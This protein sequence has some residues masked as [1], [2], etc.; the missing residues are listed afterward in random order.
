VIPLRFS[1]F[2]GERFHSLAELLLKVSDVFVFRAVAV[3]NIKVEPGS[4]LAVKDDTFAAG[5][6][7]ADFIVHI[8]PFAGEV[9][10]EKLVGLDFFEDTV[11]DGAFVFDIVGSDGGD[12]EFLAYIFNAAARLLQL[13]IIIAAGGHISSL[14]TGW[15]AYFLG[16]P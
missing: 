1:G 2:V 12:A 9:G 13:Q 3:C 16:C 15:P 8:G 6:C 14:P 5:V 7:V 11:G 10:D 4:D